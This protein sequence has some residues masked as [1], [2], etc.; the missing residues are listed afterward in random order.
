[1]SESASICAACCDNWWV[2]WAKWLAR[3]AKSAAEKIWIGSVL[4]FSNFS[5]MAKLASLSLLEDVPKNGGQL[6]DLNRCRSWFG[7]DHQRIRVVHIWSWHVILAVFS[8]VP[9]VR[10]LRV[11]LP[12]SRLVHFRNYGNADASNWQAGWLVPKSL[13]IRFDQHGCDQWSRWRR[14]PVA[15]CDDFQID[16]LPSP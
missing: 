1:M 10:L 13:S 2:V 3:W 4:G 9:A 8:L 14:T 16:P 15:Y 11:V 5:R 7:V 6:V 12:V